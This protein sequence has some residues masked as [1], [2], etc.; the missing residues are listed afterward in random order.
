MLTPP[1]LVSPNRGDL[2]FVARC[3]IFRLDS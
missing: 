3:F 1:G 2:G